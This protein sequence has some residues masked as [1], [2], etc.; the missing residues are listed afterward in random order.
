MSSMLGLE[1]LYTPLLSVRL[2]MGVAFIVFLCAGCGCLCLLS[3]RAGLS[4]L[5]AFI[6]SILFFFPAVRCTSILS[7]LGGYSHDDTI[8]EGDTTLVFFLFSLLWMF[9]RDD[10]VGLLSYPH[11]YIP[12]FFLLFGGVFRFPSFPLLWLAFFLNS[13]LWVHIVDLDM[14]FLSH[15]HEHEHSL[16]ALRF[17]IF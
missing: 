3:E 9:S 17:C 16:A 5:G 1:R 11:T 6:L 8:S 7:F 13:L 4:F 2:V 15:E 14:V 10:C 12:F